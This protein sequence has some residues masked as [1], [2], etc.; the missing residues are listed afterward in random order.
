[1]IRAS[2]WTII[3]FLVS[4][5]LVTIVSKSDLWLDIWA[6]IR[7]NMSFMKPHHHRGD[8]IETVS[9]FHLPWFSYGFVKKNSMV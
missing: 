4:Q 9:D 7:P 1:M 6:F 2:E 5:L 3:I 8:F